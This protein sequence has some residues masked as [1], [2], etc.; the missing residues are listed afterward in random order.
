[1]LQVENIE[2]LQFL[3]FCAAL[4]YSLVGFGGGS[5][6]ISL[7]AVFGI[8]HTV[9]PSIALIC[10]IIVVAGGTYHFFKNGH[11]SFSFIFPFLLFSVPL[12]YIGGTIIIEREFYQFILGIALLLSSMKMLLFKKGRF[13]A[14]ECNFRPPF[15][16][17]FSIGGILGFVSGLVGIGGGIFLSPV[18]YLC[19]WGNPKKIAATATIFILI[20]SIS[21]LVGQIHKFGGL[22][23]IKDYNSLIIS[24]FLGGQ[25]GSWFCNNRIGYR[26]IEIFTAILMAF[27][28]LKLLLI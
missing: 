14:Q 4:I 12:A 2:T 10:N 28:S 13:P 17:A 19:K 18:L 9:A 21:G 5:T 23:N 16:C 26:K 20:N 15:W 1:M 24:V 8:S 22:E 7:L 27:V 3:F 25:L 6:Y 11:I